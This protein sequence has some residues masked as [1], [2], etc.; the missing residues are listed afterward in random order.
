MISILLASLALVSPNAD[1]VIAN[2]R[3]NN[4]PTI[5]ST[6]VVGGWDEGYL[7][8]SGVSHGREKSDHK[9]TVTIGEQEG[10]IPDVAAIG[11]ANADRDKARELIVILAWRV[12]HYD[13]DGTLYE[14]RIFDDLKEGQETL[15][16]LTSQ[17]DLFGG[18]CDCTWRDGQVRHVA[19]KDIASIKKRLKQAG[20]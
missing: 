11:F 13:V 19:Y 8:V 1:H 18:E 16:Q 4:R 15:T 2:A 14:V 3:W 5:F 12:A 17:S 10:G 6:K 9:F 20:Y 7:V